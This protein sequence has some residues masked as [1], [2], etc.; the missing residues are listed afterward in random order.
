VPPRHDEKHQTLD[1]PTKTLKIEEAASGRSSEIQKHRNA[2]FAKRF[3][4]ML[5]NAYQKRVIFFGSFLLDK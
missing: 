4:R 3:W 1:L 5:K 2:E